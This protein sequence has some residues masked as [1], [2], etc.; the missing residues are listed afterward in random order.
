[1]ISIEV[2]HRHLILQTVTG[3]PSVIFM[4]ALAVLIVYNSRSELNSNRYILF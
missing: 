2:L 3:Q 4:T 1:M